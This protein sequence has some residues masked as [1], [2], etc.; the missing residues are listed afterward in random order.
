MAGG[1]ANALHGQWYHPGTGFL[2][3]ADCGPCS[4]F[5]VRA[6]EPRGRITWSN[7]E[8]HGHDASYPGYRHPKTASQATSVHCL[9]TLQAT[10]YL[11]IPLEAAT[12]M[13]ETVFYEIVAMLD[14][15][16]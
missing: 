14:A 10:L 2:N 13:V 1:E 15:R 8:S 4:A 11:N 16:R 3:A 9:R 7:H 12:S 5:L 6:C